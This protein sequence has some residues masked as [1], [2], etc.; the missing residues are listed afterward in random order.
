MLEPM[1][2]TGKCAVQVLQLPV[3]L[4]W[5]PLTGAPTDYPTFTRFTHNHNSSFVLIIVT[6]PCKEHQQQSL[7]LLAPAVIMPLLLDPFVWPSPAPLS[8]VAAMTLGADMVVPAIREGASAI[9]PCE[10]WPVSCTP[11]P[12][13]LLPGA[14]ASLSLVAHHDDWETPAWVECTIFLRVVRQ[15]TRRAKLASPAICQKYC[16]IQRLIYAGKVD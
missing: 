2:S 14:W 16:C 15:H 3:T 13:L 5:R 8:P 12:S 9:I 7:S 6:V 1:T 11:T 4:I 10:A